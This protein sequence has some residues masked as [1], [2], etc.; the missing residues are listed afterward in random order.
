MST[1]P[2]SSS[3]SPAPADARPVPRPRGQAGPIILL[4]IGALLGSSGAGLI[5]GGT[6]LFVAT[7]Q[8]QNDGY[9]TTQAETF[10]VDSYAITSPRLNMGADFNIPTVTGFDFATLRLQASAVQADQNI[11]L[12]IA[13]RAEVE[14]YLANVNVSALR[15]VTTTP[16]RVNYREVP[17]TRVPQAPESQTFWTESASGAGQQNIIWKPVPGDWS[18]VVMN[19]DASAGVAVNISAGVRTDLLGPIAAGLLAGGGL[20]FV[21]GAVLVTGGAVGL[22]R[23][24]VAAEAPASAVLAR[25]FVSRVQPISPVTLTGHLDPALSRGLWLIKWL[26][27][28]PHVIVLIGLWFALLVTTVVAA[29]AI[30]FTGRYPRSLFHFNVGVLRWSWRVAFYAYSAL[31]TD[32]YPPFT[33]A[34]TDYPADFTV[35]YP[36][37]LSRGLVFVKSWLLAIPHLA[38]LGV[39]V[40]GSNV[41]A[42]PWRGD[43][44]WR[45]GN[46]GSAGVPDGASLLGILVLIAGVILLF[47]GRYQ[48]PLFNLIMGVNRWVL[49]V[50]TYTS[51][52]RDDYPPFRLDQGPTEPEPRPEPRPEPTPEPTLP[53]DTRPQ[54]TPT[55]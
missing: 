22:G 47:T 5:A 15:E 46:F 1:T 33:L 42:Y 45:M 10:A 50:I 35:E 52:L 53:A 49:R 31:G 27:V 39:F 21:L 11:F 41:W 44:D 29:V 7:A 18:V 38:L 25:P 12:G 30:V 23:R 34:P 43:S 40:G 48:Q 28:L 4:I 17:G 26:L 16:F 6:A 54:S 3:N 20:L 14:R 2:P 55:G 32:R 13:P 24:A 37:R 19:A 51:L 36:E 8:Q 9:F